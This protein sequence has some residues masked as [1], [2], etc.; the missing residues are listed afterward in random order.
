MKKAGIYWLINSTLKEEMNWSCFA[1]NLFMKINNSNRNLTARPSRS[2]TI[3]TVSYEGLF[4]KEEYFHHC[5]KTATKTTKGK[6]KATK[7]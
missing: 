2:S 5:Q 6:K 1:M 4:H 3:W 7:F